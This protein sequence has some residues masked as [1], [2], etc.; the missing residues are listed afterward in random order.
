MKKLI[1]FLFFTSLPVYGDQLVDFCIAVNGELHRSYRCPK[2]G[3]KLPVR[4]CEYFNSQGDLQ[5]VN[6]CSGPTGGHRE[7]FFKACVVH[8][9][10]YHHEPSTNGLERR[11]CDQL[12]LRTALEG[13]EQAPNQKVCQNWA[14][15]MYNSLRLIGGPAYHCADEPANYS[16][17]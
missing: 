15:L 10:C 11:D 4:T 7:Y 12:F 3:L 14:K 8:D 9:L 17:L 6:G 1:L 13:C 2:S 16:S 5:F